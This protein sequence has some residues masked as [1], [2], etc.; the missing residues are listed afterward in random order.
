MIVPA[1][2]GLRLPILDTINPEEGAK[3]K[4]SIMS[5]LEILSFHSIPT[6]SKQM[7]TSYDYWYSLT[8]HNDTSRK[9]NVLSN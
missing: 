2:V 5:V 4:S 9:K 6:K 7:R 3:T 8:H 1:I